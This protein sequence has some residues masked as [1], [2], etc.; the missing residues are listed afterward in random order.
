MSLPNPS[1][2]DLPYGLFRN[3]KRYL[4]AELIPGAGWATADGILIADE[5]FRA[6]WEPADGY[7]RALWRS[8][9]TWPSPN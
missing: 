4:L 1:E 2:S 8:S 7:A 3:G 5:T 6:Q 9:T